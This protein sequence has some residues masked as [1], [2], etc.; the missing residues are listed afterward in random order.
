MSPEE[1]AA[2]VDNGGEG[3][4]GVAVAEVSHVLEG[5]GV[6]CD[7]NDKGFGPLRRGGKEEREEDEKGEKRRGSHSRTWNRNAGNSLIS[8]SFK[9]GGVVHSW[10]DT[11]NMWRLADGFWGVRAGVRSDSSTLSATE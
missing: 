7:G 8:C 2:D 1:G 3:H 9:L 10:D 11:W 5:A 4:H 6:F